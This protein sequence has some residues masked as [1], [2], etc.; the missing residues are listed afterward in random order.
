[1]FPGLDVGNAFDSPHDYFIG[2]QALSTL[3]KI[4]ARVGDRPHLTGVKFSKHSFGSTSGAREP[5]EY[6]RVTVL[7]A[8]GPWRQ[9]VWSDTVGS[10]AEFRLNNVGDF[11]A[12][13]RDLWHQWWAEADTTMLTVNMT[14]MP[15]NN[16]LDRSRP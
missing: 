10:T 1:M 12:W 13:E 2:E 11:V 16:L 4:P 9:R 5:T 7:V 15:P 8:G 14:Y 3:L 6:R